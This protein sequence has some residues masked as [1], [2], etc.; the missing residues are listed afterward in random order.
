MD[1]RNCK[2]KALGFDALINGLYFTITLISFVLTISLFQIN[3]VIASCAT[4]FIFIVPCILDGIKDFITSNDKR[5]LSTIIDG[6]VTIVLFSIAVMM[7]IFIFGSD[8]FLQ[9]L[10]LIEI[11]SYM[12]LVGVLRYCIIT[13]FLIYD[14]IK[15]K[16]KYK[17]K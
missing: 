3:N 8:R 9:I 14:I 17:E 15:E 11:V 7:L 10:L 16:K 2:V 1:E 12:S 5:K 4:C 13:G 6:I